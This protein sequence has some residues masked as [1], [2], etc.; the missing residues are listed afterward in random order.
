MHGV[1]L[2][3]QKT[4]KHI[5]LPFLPVTPL[6]LYLIFVSL[7]LGTSFSLAKNG[8]SRLK[9]PNSVMPILSPIIV[10]ITNINFIQYNNSFLT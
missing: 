3:K 4:H 5:W 2:G 8:G 1:G 7:T 6:Q 10:Q 9:N